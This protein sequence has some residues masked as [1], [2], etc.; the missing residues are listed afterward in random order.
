MR[1]LQRLFF[2]SHLFSLCKN[3]LFSSGIWDQ[4]MGLSS[5]VA[6]GL[7][8]H[9]CQGCNWFASTILARSFTGLHFPSSYLVSRSMKEAYI[10]HSLYT[11]RTADSAWVQRR[12]RTLCCNET[13][14][15]QTRHQNPARKTPTGPESKRH[16][17]WHHHRAHTS[18]M[19]AAQNKGLDIQV[20]AQGEASQI[21]QGLSWLLKE[22]SSRG[23]TSTQEGQH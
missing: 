14:A 12:R 4:G 1:P 17:H 16:H 23:H 6:M 15:K 3:H 9:P 13:L 19:I 7:I 5:F 2:C 10:E 21:K 22:E 11:Q 18:T 8:G 20:T